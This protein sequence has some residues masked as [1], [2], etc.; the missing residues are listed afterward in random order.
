MD[1]TKDKKTFNV[2]DEFMFGPYLLVAPVYQYG[3]RQRE[4]YLPEGN[5]WYDLYSGKDVGNG[6]IMAAAPYERMPLFVK[7]GAILPLGPE[8]QWT[9]ENPGGDITLFV[10]EGNNGEFTLYDDEGL[11]YNY[12]KGQYAEIPLKWDNSTSTLT[13]G[14]R[15]G[16]YPGM[17]T[18]RKFKVVKVNK[19]NPIGFSRDVKGEVFNYT[20]EEI[21]VKL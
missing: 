5:I 2:S 7:S 9:G 21:K 17:P 11:N 15:N 8:I 16:E 10:Y 6:E 19:E 18:D 4:V 13:I 12:E 20:G 3:A 1:F 14:K